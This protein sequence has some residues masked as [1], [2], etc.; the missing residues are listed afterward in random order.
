MQYAWVAEFG[1][2]YGAGS[3]EQTYL[4]VVKGPI[5]LHF[6]ADVVVY[7]RELVLYACTYS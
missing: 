5:L 1:T 3:K 7:L 2:F 6:L 4:G